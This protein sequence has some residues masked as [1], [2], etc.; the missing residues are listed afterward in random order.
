M[1]AGGAF[2]GW[3]LFRESSFDANIILENQELS[4]TRRGWPYL[5]VFATFLIGL[6]A[7]RQVASADW[8]AVLEGF[9]RAGSL[10]F[11]GGHVVLPLLDSF[12]VGQGWIDQ[13]RFLAGYG[14][15]QALPGPLFAFS[16]FL[17]ASLNVGPGGVLGGA[18]AVLAIY[19]PSCLLVLG[20]LPYW[21]RL[22]RLRTARAALAGTN[23]AVVGLL[24]AA[25]YDPIWTTAVTDAARF[26]FALAA[27]A[28]I[29]S[30][31]LS[32]WRLVLVS[33]ALGQVWF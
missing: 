2:L 30:G 25:F 31:A 32:P 21:E 33:G 4:T 1:I 11:G 12:T 20:A 17:G 26:V 16:G 18:L 5:L 13:S 23:A 3:W 24:L 9:Y 10:V 29:R 15:A 6:P 28:L 19:L 22:R 7:I 27:F 8:L 14:A